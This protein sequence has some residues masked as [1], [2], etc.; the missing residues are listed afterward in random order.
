M[1]GSDYV[2]EVVRNVKVLKKLRKKAIRAVSKAE[3]VI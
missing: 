1:N 3:I 2:P